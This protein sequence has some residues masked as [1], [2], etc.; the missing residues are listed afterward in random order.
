MKLHPNLR[1]RGFSLVEQMVSLTC[2]LIVLA[3]VLIA[4]VAL[5]RS[6]AAVEGYSTAEGDQLRVQD[7]IAMDCRRAVGGVVASNTLTL[8]IPTYYD[9]GSKNP[10]DPQHPTGGSIQ[11]GTGTVPISYYR[12]GSNF[13]RQVNGT[14]FAI[15]TNV[16]SFTV[17]PQDLT[18]SVTCSVTFA[19]RFTNMPNVGPVN[20]TTVFSNTFLRNAVAR[21]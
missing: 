18:S 2:G 15:A 17:T 16:E 4:G 10:V 11:Y 7:Y 19:P 14:E 1:I 12:S 9:P 21:Q 13:I 3:A 20:G 6:F 5:Q 8:S